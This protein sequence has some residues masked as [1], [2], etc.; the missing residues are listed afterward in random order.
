MEFSETFELKRLVNSKK[1]FQDQSPLTKLLRSSRYSFTSSS[2]SQQNLI[3]LVNDSDESTCDNRKSLSTSHI[4]LKFEPDFTYLQDAKKNNRTSFLT[5]QLNRQ[6]TFATSKLSN[7]YKNSNIELS[8]YFFQ[9]S[10]SLR[11]T[12]PFEITARDTITKSILAY[13]QHGSI[14]LTLDQDYY[15]LWIADE[16]T[17]QPDFDYKI[18]RSQQISSLGVTCFSLCFKQNHPKLQLDCKSG[19]SALMQVQNNEK[20]FVKFF[21]ESVSTVIQVKSEQQVI[22]T[23]PILI[24][25]FHIAGQFNPDLAEVKV[26]VKETGSECGLDLG[27]R[28]G[29]IKHKEFRL[30]KK[31]LADRPQV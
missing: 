12:V 29:E 19:S 25:K 10:F 20:F 5:L 18:G 1:Q 24:K 8:I 9:S 6:T 27:L 26:L 11:I 31:V 30:C 16:D 2:N 15:D 23:L 21:F 4:E 7:S 14:P 28:F 3:R 17:F 13:E 22:E